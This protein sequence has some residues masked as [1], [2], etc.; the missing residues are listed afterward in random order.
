M[1]C[2]VADAYADIAISH[3]DLSKLI[4]VD[5]SIA[6]QKALSK[7]L[8]CLS[9][10]GA[11]SRSFRQGDA[12]A[13]DVLGISK[14]VASFTDI[15]MRQSIMD[16]LSSTLRSSQPYR[17]EKACSTIKKRIERDEELSTADIKGGPNAILHAW[18]G[19]EDT[20]SLELGQEVTDRVRELLWE[21]GVVQAD[22]EIF[23][24]HGI[25]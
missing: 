7:L 12:G 23:D 24:E 9:E 13:P 20:E 17:L 11:A 3:Q 16:A 2:A 25:F 5:D 14:L 18:Y 8:E 15:G 1:S 19:A 4:E 10:P 21:F 6:K 22:P